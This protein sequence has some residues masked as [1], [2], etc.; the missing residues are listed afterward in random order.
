MH[1][2]DQT[3]EEKAA[4][5]Q[6]FLKDPRTARKSPVKVHRTR[7]VAVEEEDEAVEAN[8]RRVRRKPAEVA[9][10][11]GR[12]DASQ[13]W[14]TTSPIQVSRQSAAWHAQS[15]SLCSEWGFVCDTTPSLCKL[16]MYTSSKPLCGHII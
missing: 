6:E 7:A 12:A 4:A 11:P 10:R 1:E 15:T 8:A 2:S 16:V 3:D 9:K 5:S 14:G 13:P